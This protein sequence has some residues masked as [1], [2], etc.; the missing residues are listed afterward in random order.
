MGTTPI[1][2]LP[3]PEPTDPVAQGADAIKALANALDKGVAKAIAA[4][5]ATLPITALNTGA[6]VAVT[7]PAGRFTAAPYVFGTPIIGGAAVGP[8]A[9]SGTTPNGCTL[10][11]QKTAGAISPLTVN[12]LAIQF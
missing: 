9:V 4:G 10:W 8:I 7:F 11:G 5:S 12:W 2:A 6:S 1:N 3:Y